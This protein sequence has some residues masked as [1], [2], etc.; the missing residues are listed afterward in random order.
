MNDLG[1]LSQCMMDSDAAGSGR[2]KRLRGKA[3]AASLVLEAVAIACVLLWPL[4]TLGVLSAQM[5][6]TPV[7][8][9]Q[10][11]QVSHPA[12]PGQTELHPS[13]RRSITD[14][15]FQQPPV[16]P[17]HIA[18]STSLEPPNMDG[19]GDPSAE[20]GSA[21]WIPGGNENGP[22]VEIARPE[23]RSKPR[24]ISLGVM[25]ASLIHRV[26]PE[27]P[28][29]AKTIHLSGS[30]LLRAV[31]GTD[32]DVHSLE[33]LSGNPILAQAALAAV[34]QWRYR[35]TLLSGQPVEVETQ[36]TVNF[37]LE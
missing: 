25:D 17:A 24:M 22:A 14:H 11:A 20:P 21:A 26:Q 31:I 19:M 27:Y 6:L 16:I 8:P 1:N 28:P 5:V 37:V 30:V 35:P 12:P 4:A 29:I 3:L 32:G 18:D 2:A 15:I 13:N 7:P 33:V 36:I 23:P 34:R 10:G 9:Y